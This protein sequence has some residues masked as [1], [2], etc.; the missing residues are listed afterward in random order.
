M[1]LDKLQTRF[2]DEILHGATHVILTGKWFVL[3]SWP[4]CATLTAMNKR[5][6][7]SYTP[8]CPFWEPDVLA[9]V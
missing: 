9:F 6:F 1:T 8:F 7:S 4:T 5:Q 3:R 2:V